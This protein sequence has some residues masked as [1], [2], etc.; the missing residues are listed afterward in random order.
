MNADESRKWSQQRINLMLV[1]LI[2]RIDASLAVQRIQLSAT[3]VGVWTLER[4]HCISPKYR[5]RSQSQ[6]VV[7]SFAFLGICDSWRSIFDTI[8]LIALKCSSGTKKRKIKI[9]SFD[10]HRLYLFAGQ[11]KI[12]TQFLIGPNSSRNDPFHLICDGIMAATQRPISKGPRRIFV[13]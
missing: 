1:A 5:N 12:L 2:D 6:T 7:D 4:K 13:P 10:Y 9:D 8:A 11:I 3:S